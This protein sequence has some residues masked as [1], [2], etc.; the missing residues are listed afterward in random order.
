MSRK[1]FSKYVKIFTFLDITFD[2]YYSFLDIYLKNFL[3]KILIW[4][5]GQ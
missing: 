5:D 2:P 1:N 3:F 4:L